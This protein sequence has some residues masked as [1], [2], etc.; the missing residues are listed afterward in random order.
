MHSFTPGHFLYAVCSVVFIV[1]VAG[2]VFEIVHVRA[3]QHV[4]QLHKVAMRLVLHWGWE[5]SKSELR[6]SKCTKKMVFPLMPIPSTIPQGYSLPLTLCPRASTTVLL[7]ITANGVH[8]C[9]KRH[10]KV[11]SCQLAY[12]NSLIR[13]SRTHLQLLVE[14]FELLVLVG[15]AFRELVHL[16]P[17]LV[18]FLSYLDVYTQDDRSE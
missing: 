16:D 8:S 10:T 17:K 1:D 11:G 2:H 9:T 12:S 13:P 18:D 7:P 14:L 5:H 3:N 6:H 15:V 4:P